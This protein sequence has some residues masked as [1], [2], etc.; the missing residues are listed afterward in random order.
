MIGSMVDVTARKREE[1]AQRFLAQAATLLDSS[2][3][4]QVVKVVRQW[5]GAGN[6]P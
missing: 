5:L 6:A 4:Q 3:E 2:L 1:E